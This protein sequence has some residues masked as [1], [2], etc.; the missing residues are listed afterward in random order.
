MN[1]GQLHTWRRQFEERPN[2]AF[3]G[4]GRRRQ[5]EAIV[6]ELE[7][8]IGQQAVAIDFLKGCLRQIGEKGPP[9]SDI[10]LPAGG[11][12]CKAGE[13]TASKSAR[14]SGHD[15]SV[16]AQGYEATFP[17]PLPP[18]DRSSLTQQALR[19]PE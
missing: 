1:H 14:L 3:S 8:K 18:Q 6:A 19:L 15:E 16:Y 5:E 4:E 10:G 9:K 17:A 12:Q 7:G 13:Q 11:C 2:S